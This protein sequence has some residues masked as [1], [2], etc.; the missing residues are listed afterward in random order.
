MSYERL[1][2]GLHTFTVKAID[3]ANN[4]DSDP[5]S[6]TWAID[7][8][9]PH[10][11]ITSQPLIR[12][13]STSA[14]FGFS[15]TKTGS[16]FQCRIDGGAF[17]VCASPMNYTGLA[18]GSHAFTVA[19]ID[20]VGNIDPAP[21]RYTWT[22]DTTPFGTA[23]TSQPSNPTNETTASFS[24]TS[25]KSRATFQCALD[26][27]S[28]SSCSSPKTYSGLA[29]E[30]HTFM[31]KAIDDLGNEDTSPARYAWEIRV[32]PINTTPLG[33]INRRGAY[34]TDKEIVKLS[35]SAT[36]EKG[37]TGYFASESPATPDA[38][39]PG[40]TKFPAVKVY[41]RDVEYAV[42]ETTGQKRVYV[43]FQDDSG[44]VSGA[45]SDTIYRFNS[46]Y[47]MLMFLL[48]QVALVIG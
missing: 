21:A 20:A 2:E 25:R 30:S 22:I 14:S 43:W 12:T 28:Y 34:F 10:T 3:R 18:A 31:V 48:L 44:S 41:S 37:V 38:S 29:E 47:L 16:T 4:S 39:D 27:G 7:T 8:A 36:S 33:F 5:P 15:S 45:Q 42:S 46:N 24:F 40:W 23:I 1:P 26:G 32:P 13:N 6:F 17:A 35:I 9:P 11:A 19:A